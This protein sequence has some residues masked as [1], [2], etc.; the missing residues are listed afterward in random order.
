ME[1][2]QWTAEQVL[3]LTLPGPA[4][5]TGQRRLLALATRMRR[6]PGVVD[7]VPGLHSLSLVMDPQRLAPARLES[8]ARQAWQR[9]RP[10][11][12]QVVERRLVVRYGGEHGPDLEEAAGLLGLSPAQLVDAHA[13]PCYEVACLGFLP[14]FAYLLGLPPALQ[15]P[16]RDVPRL[17]VPAGSVG[18]GGAQTGVY[19]LDSP[20]GWQLLGRT[21][22]R[23]FDASLD[24]SSWLLP[25]DRLRFEPDA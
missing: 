1:Q 6:E 18:I 2:W 12:E 9:A 23:L 24:E 4:E 14:G 5:M 11:R 8:L 16:R 3:Q 19:P 15:L 22:Q 7:A 10:V 17:R 13:A 21:E 25:G 20:G